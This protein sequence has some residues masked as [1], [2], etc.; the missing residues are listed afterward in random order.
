[1]HTNTFPVDGTNIV[2]AH[3][4]LLQVGR[5]VRARSKGPL[6]V[7]QLS[8]MVGLVLPS[9]GMGFQKTVNYTGSFVAAPS[10]LM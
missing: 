4:A 10:R 6:S 7:R 3:P 5:K 8:W 2:I 9:Q 1:M